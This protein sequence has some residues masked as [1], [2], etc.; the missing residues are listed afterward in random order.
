MSAVFDQ[1]HFPEFVH[2]VS[3][4]RAGRADHFRQRL[5]TQ[6]G[7]CGIRRSAV[8]AK[9]RELQENPRQPLLAMV[10]K[11]IAE[12][13]LRSILR[14]NKRAKNLSENSA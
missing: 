6:F 1:M 10:E 11:L 5:V 9:V 3:N 8:L 7:Y 14:A 2:E 13:F 12:I 4:A